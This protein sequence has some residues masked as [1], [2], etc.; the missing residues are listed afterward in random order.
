MSICKGKNPLNKNIIGLKSMSVVIE[1]SFITRE[2][3]TVD[4][5]NIWDAKYNYARN[6]KF[7]YT[8]KNEYT[9]NYNL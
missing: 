1:I 6:V 9:R 5:I 8:H 3:T 2:F 4:R 7:N